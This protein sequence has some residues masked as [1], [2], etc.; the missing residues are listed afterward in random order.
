MGSSNNSLGLSKKIK[1]SEIIS[2]VL[3]QGKR[4]TSYP[5]RIHWLWESSPYRSVG[6][7]FEVAFIVPKRI[8]R[9]A[10]KR[11]Q[12]KRWM[13]EALRIHQDQILIKEKKQLQL[14]IVA[15]Q[16]EIST[17][18]EV[19]KAVIYLLTYLANK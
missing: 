14:L 5:I 8:Y 2:K 10:V 19:E 18:Q 1:K 15:S 3:K 11:N 7:G 4:K 6:S 12:I 16:A 9:K 13:R 17:Y